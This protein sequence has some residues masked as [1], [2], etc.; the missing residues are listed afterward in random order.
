MWTRTLRFD[1]R[2]QGPDYHPLRPGLEGGPYLYAFWH[3]MLLVPVAL[4]GRTGAK[5]LISKSRDGQLLASIAHF[6]G[7]EPVRGSSSRGGMEAVRKLVRIAHPG[8]LGVTP[9]GPRGPRRQV[10]IGVIYLASRSGMPLVAAGFA[11][12]QGWRFNSWDRFLLPRPWTRAACVT[13]EAI[14]VPPDASRE[15]LEHYR[16]RLQEA[17]DAN[18]VAA[19]SLVGGAPDTVR[20]LATR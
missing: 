5:V 16:Q 2:P 13:T 15:E 7:F 14:V 6:L 8:H 10:Q 12:A 1:Y 3:E 18:Q 4:F 19:E 20:D 17:L 9:D 11:V